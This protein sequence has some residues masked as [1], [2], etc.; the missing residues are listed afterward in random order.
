M[1]N[2]KELAPRLKDLLSGV[3][4][5]GNQHLLEVEVDLIQTTALLGAAIDKLLT[6]FIAIH[7]AVN[8]QQEAV[9]LLISGKQPSVEDIERLK[10]IQSEVG[11]HVNTAV[12]SMQ[13][14]DLTNQLIGRTVKRV[15]GL[16]D[17]LDSLGNT[18]AQMLP[19]SG[20][21]EIIAFLSEINNAL[22]AQSLELEGA[23][24][25]VVSQSKMDS[26][27]IELF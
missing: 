23:L 22:V 11:R 1:A 18:G 10:N 7:E 6:S 15:A 24:R 26:G 13:F 9:N 4:N 12:T 19:E 14:Q 3:S 2:S 16:R 8:F 17:A 27:D 20:G 21:E 25:I 5:Y